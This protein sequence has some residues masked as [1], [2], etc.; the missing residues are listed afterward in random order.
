MNTSSGVV[1]SAWPRQ[2]AQLYSKMYL[3]NWPGTEFN[4]AYRHALDIVALLDH[5]FVTDTAD[6]AV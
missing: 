1:A 5:T 6:D 2:T 4:I 3:I